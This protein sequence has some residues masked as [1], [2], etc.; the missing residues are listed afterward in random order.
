MVLE[1]I[2]EIQSVT[3]EPQPKG[4]TMQSKMK[5]SSIDLIEVLEA[6]EHA[7]IMKA[8]RIRKFRKGEIL[9]S[10]DTEENYVFILKEGRVRIFLSSPSREFLLSILS[11]GDVYSSHTR[12]SC[13]ALED[14]SM[15]VCPVNEFHRIAVSHSEFTMTMVKVLGELLSSSFSIIDGF[16]FRN[17][18][19][20]LALFLYE[21]AL[22][23]GKEGDGGVILETSL[24]VEQIAQMLGASR[25]MVSTLL[26]GMYKSGLIEKVRRGTFFIPDMEKLNKA[27]Q[28]PF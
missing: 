13:E 23:N 2:Q 28:L 15:F 9:N 25:Q 19:L 17:T 18:E 26:N 27:A 22:S 14:G 10:P 21:E 12:A 20:R 1:A 8:F 3:S 5:L 6:P 11:P 24:T 16:A 7:D 4:G